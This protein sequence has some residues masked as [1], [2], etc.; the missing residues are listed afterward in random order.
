[1]TGLYVLKPWYARQLVPVV[2]QLEQARVSPDAV[3]LC[4]VLF[5]ACGGLVLAFVPSGAAAGLLVAI[6][7]AARLACANMDGTLA[8]SR[9]SRPVGGI[10]N[11][12]G[13]RLADAALL[14]GLCTHLTWAGIVLAAAALPSWAALTVAG[15]G[16]PR[17]NSGPMGKT[18]RCVV[19]AVAA[20]SG[21]FAACGALIAVGS[22]ITAAVRLRRGAAAVQ[23]VSR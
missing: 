8:R 17:S 11:E 9:P 3:S 18:E 15:H 20:C 6:C 4:G 23:A 10:V 19:A 5:G 7:V 21:W 2:D 22:V 12:L 13:D 1:M 14:A 16:G